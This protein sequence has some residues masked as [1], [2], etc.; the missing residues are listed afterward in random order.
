MRNKIEQYKAMI[1]YSNTK[2]KIEELL[3]GSHFVEDLIQMC[4]LDS[5]L[6]DIRDAISAMQKMIEDAEARPSSRQN[7]G[8]EEDVP[9]YVVIGSDEENDDDKS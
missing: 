5:K 2:E 8:E 6:T 1:T 3:G 9:D 4:D 7:E